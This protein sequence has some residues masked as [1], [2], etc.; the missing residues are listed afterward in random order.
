[1]EDSYTDQ[2]QTARF[3]G[4]A[5]KGLIAWAN[6]PTCKHQLDHEGRT[7]QEH[8]LSQIMRCARKAATAG[9]KALA[10]RDLYG[11]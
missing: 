5:A 10:L 7:C 8:H 4:Q 3:Y 1:M 11:F 9:R 2:L 6:E